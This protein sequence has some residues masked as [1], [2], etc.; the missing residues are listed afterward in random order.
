MHS[1]SSVF[2]TFIGWA[3]S[4]D[5]YLWPSE[6]NSYNE[7]VNNV[8]YNHDLACSGGSGPYHEQIEAYVETQVF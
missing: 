6:A 3:L 2:P 7:D 5:E 8:G 1:R 4:L